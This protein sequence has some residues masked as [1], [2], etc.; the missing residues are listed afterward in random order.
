MI[1]FEYGEKVLAF[2]GEHV[3]GHFHARVTDEVTQV[4]LTQALP[5]GPHG[6]HHALEVRVARLV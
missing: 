2:H 5:E 4:L 3:V 6:G 1:S